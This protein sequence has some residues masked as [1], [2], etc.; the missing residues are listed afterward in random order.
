MV[1]QL[2][3]RLA[4]LIVARRVENVILSEQRKSGQLG[5]FDKIDAGSELRIPILEK[6]PFDRASFDEQPFAKQ[7]EN[8]LRDYDVKIQGANFVLKNPNV[9]SSPVGPD[10]ET[11][12]PLYALKAAFESAKTAISPA[13]TGKVAL[14]AL[15]SGARNELAPNSDI[16]FWIVPLDASS[17]GYA[18]AIE[19]NMRE[20]LNTKGLRAAS[21]SQVLNYATPETLETR[22]NAGLIKISPWT[23]LDLIFISGDE[24]VAGKTALHVNKLLFEH[25]DALRARLVSEI[26]AMTSRLSRVSPVTIRVKDVQRLAQ[27]YIYAARL[28]Y[29]IKDKMNVASVVGELR[30]RR[31]IKLEQATKLIEDYSYLSTVRND[32]ERGLIKPRTDE[33]ATHVA[34]L[35]TT[36]K[37]LTPQL[38]SGP[39]AFVKTSSPLEP[40]ISSAINIK[41]EPVQKITTDTNNIGKGGL[42]GAGVGVGVGDIGGPGIGMGQGG[43]ID[44]PKIDMP[45]IPRLQM[46]APLKIA[47]LGPIVGNIPKQSSLPL[48][49]EQPFSQNNAKNSPMA[50]PPAP[51]TL[52]TNNTANGAGSSTSGSGNRHVGAVTTMFGSETAMIGSSPVTPP[53]VTSSAI[54]QIGINTITAISSRNALNA[55]SPGITVAAAASPVAGRGSREAGNKIEKFGALVR[56]GSATT[57]APVISA[58]GVVAEEARSRSTSEKGGRE[59]RGARGAYS[60][61]TVEIAGA[62]AL[63]IS[64]DINIGKGTNALGT[65]AGSAARTF[66]VAKVV[67]ENWPEV[68]AKSDNFRSSIRV[69]SEGPVVGFFVPKIP[70]K[71]IASPINRHLGSLVGLMTSDVATHNQ[72]PKDHQPIGN[73]GAA[74]GAGQGKGTT[75][76][77]SGIGFAGSAVIR[78]G[79]E[80]HRPLLNE[81]IPS[82]TDINHSNEKFI[83][84]PLEH[85]PPMTS[86]KNLPVREEKKEI[87]P[88]PI[89]QPNQ[90]NMNGVNSD[91]GKGLVSGRIVIPRL[92][93]IGKT[94]LPLV[95]RALV[96]GI[97]LVTMTTGPPAAATAPVSAAIEVPSRS[98]ELPFKTE[99]STVKNENIDFNEPYAV[100]SRGRETNT[101]IVMRSAQAAL[102]QG[103]TPAGARITI[104]T[105]GGV[106]CVTLSTRSLSS[107]TLLSLPGIVR[108]SP[109]QGRLTRGGYASFWSTKQQ[110]TSTPVT[111]ES[112]LGKRYAGRIATVF[113]PVSSPL[114]I[115]TYPYTRSTVRTIDGG[116]RAVVPASSPV[117][118]RAF[119]SMALTAAIALN[120]IYTTACRTEKPAPQPVQVISQQLVK[121]FLTPE[122]IKWVKFA[123]RPG[124]FEYGY[125][126]EFIAAIALDENLANVNNG[127]RIKEWA[128]GLLTRM[129]LHNGTIGLCQVSATI[130]TDLPFVEELYRH[131]D[132]FLNN[133]SAKD[134]EQ[135][136]AAVV[137]P[138]AEGEFSIVELLQAL[139]D[140]Y[141]N[142]E[143]RDRIR[144]ALRGHIEARESKFGTMADLVKNVEGVNLLAARFMISKNLK[145]LPKDPSLW[146][147]ANLKTIAARYSGQKNDSG[148]RSERKMELY[149]RI[150]DAGIFATNGKGSSSP[151]ASSP[152]K[153]R[154]WELRYRW[155]EFKDVLS[156]L[157]SG[158]GSAL[159]HKKLASIMLVGMFAETLLA[160]RI[161]AQSLYNDIYRK[162][163]EAHYELAL[164]DA[165]IARVQLVT[166]REK[167]FEDGVLNDEEWQ[168]V[169]GKINE[170]NA[171][172]LKLVESAETF[173]DALKV[174]NVTKINNKNIDDVLKE[175]RNYH[176][177]LSETI[178]NQAAIE[179]EVEKLSGMIKSAEITPATPKVN[180]QPVNMAFQAQTGKVS[181]DLTKAQEALGFILRQRSEKT[182][183]V[184]SYRVTDSSFDKYSDL[185]NYASTYDQALAAVTFTISGQRDY[186]R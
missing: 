23:F 10:N 156:G 123:A 129:G 180:I 29:G 26:N 99:I 62:R 85:S 127:Q 112:I 87:P 184:A 168:D 97:M 81:K 89:T 34:S 31:A 38:I 49:T 30:D 166:S 48:S 147:E 121:E 46:S 110:A 43:R 88:K 117:D 163:A 15:G 95:L 86:A 124:Q 12:Q 74:N 157:T 71:T 109:L 125:K 3:G 134:K 128:S 150:K 179:E 108:Y 111:E 165:D 181:Q 24:A 75:G 92:Q 178:K 40:R 4:P 61:G 105:K 120:S 57:G 98:I 72:I 175:T 170:H 55:R 13:L 83:N 21:F 100:P 78:G 39:T 158:I 82:I 91:I 146:T 1:E 25:N 77:G 70:T 6:V 102:L 45:K 50:Q 37:D 64:K 182:G 140:P 79:I 114:V 18:R 103:L 152:I 169:S 14:Y 144:Y 5:L 7:A 173:I 73:Q 145:G 58:S 51:T 162:T 153:S 186:A 20:R 160:P 93:I 65:S 183:L 149:H 130:A 90:G 119:L 107:I 33:F 44:I 67:I 133:L 139:N 151:I 16:D 159:R 66:K 54:G 161:F 8:L 96:V 76:F 47:K 84:L 27:Y 138:D 17:Q 9:T 116:V 2:A 142:L 32:T 52:P 126:P 185:R 104:I 68:S 118:R 148:L 69:T 101:A 122:R 53:D 60:E 132:F 171:K 11:I 176:N 59:I 19:S 106:P 28:K 141:K 113:S 177:Q 131:Q 41:V 80:I 174:N 137:E 22:M 135:F 154:N 63:P 56:L 136:K 94:R 36:I 167:A 164:K 143:D 35:V 42:N 115:T 155:E 172:Q